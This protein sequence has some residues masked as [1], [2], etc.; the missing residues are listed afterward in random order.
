MSLFHLEIVFISKL[1]A[2]NKDSMCL[3]TI[4]HLY[5]FI[6]ISVKC[7]YIHSFVIYLFSI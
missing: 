5:L 6:S 2:L 7:N 1:N 4:I 3:E